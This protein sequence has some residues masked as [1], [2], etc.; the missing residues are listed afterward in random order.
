MTFVILNR[1]RPPLGGLFYFAL[2]YLR[3]GINRQGGLRI[4]SLQ[5]VFVFEM[6]RFSCNSFKVCMTYQAEYNR[7]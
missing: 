2:V 4:R 6:S 3:G 1:I 7:A 5:S